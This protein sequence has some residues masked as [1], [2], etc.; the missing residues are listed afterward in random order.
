MIKRN[1]RNDCYTK[2]IPH[3]PKPKVVLYP[4][5]CV[6]LGWQDKKNVSWFSIR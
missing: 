6:Q 3:L 2:K 1:E 4:P 5:E